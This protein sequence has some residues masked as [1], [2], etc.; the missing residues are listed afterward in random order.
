MKSYDDVIE[1]MK[2]RMAESEAR[3]ESALAN[4]AVKIAQARSELTVTSTRVGRVRGRFARRGGSAEVA[5][6]VCLCGAK[7]DAHLGDVDAGRVLDCGGEHHRK[8]YAIVGVGTRRVKIG[9]AIDV[10]KRGRDLQVGSP[11]ELMLI[12]ECRTNIEKRMHRE[13][14]RDHLHG[15]WFKLTP[16]V[17]VAIQTKFEARRHSFLG[18]LHDGSKRRAPVCNACGAVGHPTVKCG[19]WARV[20]PEERLIACDEIE[21]TAGGRDSLGDFAPGEDSQEVHT[22]RIGRILIGGLTLNQRLR[23]AELM[24]AR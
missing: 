14:D 11:V 19:I 3:K 8:T 10:L 1:R 24:G 15:E 18:T 13:L 4:E 20:L 12:G 16:A 2:A 5:K 23:V 21:P 22:E 6:C 9:S 17:F 7:F